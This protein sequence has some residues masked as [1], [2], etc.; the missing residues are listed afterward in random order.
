M[1][2]FSIATISDS[3]EVTTQGFLKTS[4]FL[5]RTGV[6]VYRRPDGTIKRELRHPDDV[7][8]SESL[9]SLQM[10]PLTDDHPKEFVTPANVKS[11]SIG[12]VNEGI[13]KKGDMVSATVVVAD[14]NAI[15]KTDKGKVEL[16]C[17]YTADVVDENDV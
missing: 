6:F 11:L 2:R 10:A 16:S 12:W 4:A 15:E 14:K 8:D 3:T 5:T 7:F 9:R 1:K 17:G 13:E